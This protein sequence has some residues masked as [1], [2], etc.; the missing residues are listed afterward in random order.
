MSFEKP[1]FLRAFL[2]LRLLH[3]LAANG[4]VVYWPPSRWAS[5]GSQR[6]PESAEDSVMDRECAMAERW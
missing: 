3:E 1:R 4:Y 6:T 2:F 5:T